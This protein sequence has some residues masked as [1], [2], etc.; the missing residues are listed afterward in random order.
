MFDDIQR[1]GGIPIMWKTGHSLIKQK[2]KDEEALLA[3][4]FSGHIFIKDRYFGYDDAIYTTLRLI[5]IMKTTGKDIKELL[6]DVPK[7]Y[8]T[9]EIRIDCSDDKKKDVVEQ[10]VSKFIKYKEN[11]NAPY[12]IRDIVTKDGIR[13]VIDKRWGLVRASNTQPVVVMRV[14][15][16][17]EK[18]MEDYKMFLKNELTEAME[19]I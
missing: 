11:G 12:H 3:G 18:S 7:A 14:E 9:P 6:S 8:H 19:T 4:E 15:A 16:E 17:D 10:V 5:E 1:N 2:M 13:I